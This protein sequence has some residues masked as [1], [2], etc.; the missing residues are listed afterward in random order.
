MAELRVAAFENGSFNPEVR[1]KA[2]LLGVVT[3]GFRLVDVGLTLVRVDGFDCTQ[4]LLE[5][6]E[7][8]KGKFDLVL[9]ASLAYAGFNVVDPER[10]QS[11]LGRPV[12]VVLSR[13]PRRRAVERALKRHFPDWRLRLQVLSKIGKPERLRL[14]GGSLYFSPFGLKRGE[15][16]KI[17]RELTVFGG[18]PE[19]LRMAG[20]LARGLG[21]WR[22]FKAP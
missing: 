10:V 14:H 21:F 16:R 8:W 6:A 2:F 13:K 5:L 3:R 19:P 20:L 22:G 12:L 18:K 11:R 7:P 15:A 4:K 1:G 17:L 9:L